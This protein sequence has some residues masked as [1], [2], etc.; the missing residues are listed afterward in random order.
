MKL[1]H[2]CGAQC[3]DD[4]ELCTVCGAELASAQEYLRELE[5]KQTAEK[6]IIKNPVLAASV[7]DIVTAE[8][9]RDVLTDNGIPFSSDESED[10]N[11]MKITFGGGFVAQDIYVDES[12]LD[13]AVELYNE[14]LNSECDFEAFEEESEFEEE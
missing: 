6:Q 11:T 14:V 9:Y 1:C 5:E 2:V 12:D 13:R 4:A 8:I 7:E 10:E 3:E